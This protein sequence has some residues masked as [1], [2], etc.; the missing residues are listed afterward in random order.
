[1]KQVLAVVISVAILLVGLPVMSVFAETVD[2]SC[3]NNVT[4]SLDTES[5]QLTI[6]GSGNMDDYYSRLYAPWYSK[7]E[8]VQSVYVEKGVTGI[9]SYAFYG[10][11][12]LTSVTV[13]SGVT[14][15]G[16]C[17]F[18][19]CS[20]LSTVTI[21]DSLEKI[22]YMAFDGCTGLTEFSVAPG[23]THYSSQNGLLLNVDKTELLLCPSGM[24]DHFEVPGGITRIESY[25]FYGCGN[26]TSVTIT[27]NVKSIG[28]YAFYKCN[29]LTSVSIS[30]SVTSIDSYVFGK[31]ESLTS[32]TIPGSIA[33]ISSNAFENCTALRSVTIQDGV[34]EIGYM[35]FT[36]CSNLNSITIPKS[37]TKIDT[38][39]FYECGNLAEISVESENTVYS[40]VD[41]ILTN[42]DKT[43]LL[44]CP[45]GKKGSVVVPDSVTSVSDYT[46][47][48]CRQLTSVTLPNHITRIGNAVFSGCS[49]LTNVTLPDDITSIGG[50]AFSGCSSLTD[51]TIPDGTLSIDDYA[52]K[53][54]SKLSSVVLPDSVA[55][56]GSGAFA[57][58]AYYNN[59]SNWENSVL[60]IGHHL[61]E[62]DKGFSGAYTV[63]SGTKTIAEEAFSGCSGLTSVSIP[64][65]VTNIGWRAFYSCSNLSSI[66]IADGVMNIGDFA[67]YGTAYYED[68]TNWENGILFIGNHL[69]VAKSSL[70]GDYVV[71]SGTRTIAEKAF[72]LC[73]SLT[74]V[75]IPE[76]TTSIGRNAFYSCRN[77]TSV[78]IPYTVTNIGEK[79][80]AYCT[81]NPVIYGYSVTVAEDYARDNGYRFIPIMTDLTDSQSNVTISGD[82]PAKTKL[83]VDCV[84]ATDTR[85]TYDIT[86]VQNG[87]EVQPNGAV[88]VKI[89]VPQGMNSAECRVYRNDASGR[90]TDMYATYQDGYM[91]FTTD[92][93]SKYVL[94]NQYIQAATVGDAND[95]G[96]INLDDV[97]VLAQY[98][99]EWD[100]ECNE[101]ALDTNGDGIVNLDDIVHLA[102]YVAEW[103]GIVL[104]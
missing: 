60:L 21:P 54:C 63:P 49:S 15:F 33:T 52:F 44:D 95:D 57:N 101:A 25:A 85:V 58:T 82:L 103:E 70:S 80:F 73:N 91:V 1:M 67:F 22:G 51:V 39:V 12:N 50:Y 23:N 76:G 94:T 89:P 9:G 71:P 8:T 17:A 6:S 99:A 40:S 11:S 62:A 98:V 16:Q 90:Y 66:L 30:D 65:S 104:G 13:S 47:S 36:R 59:T 78:T 24:K 26:L 96:N 29:R 31:C 74:T 27:S 84:G 10:C 46:F 79:I 7:K 20:S 64:D 34:K 75:T 93:F 69:I 61:I 48:E 68:E 100:I 45:E 83:T 53:D 87:E 92:H 2:G 18:A 38:A 55:S 86:L 5:G 88:T 14:S 72:Y 102:Q 56:I 77:L 43:V 35:A 28:M 19:D 4:W 3:G 42:Q 41:G 37:V 97:V 81:Y 32:V